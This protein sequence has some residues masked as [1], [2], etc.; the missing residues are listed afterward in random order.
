MEYKQRHEY[1]IITKQAI[2]A[3][4]TRQEL[5]EKYQYIIAFEKFSRI[6]T[7]LLLPTTITYLDLICKYTYIKINKMCD[8]LLKTE[9]TFLLIS[10]ALKNVILFRN[11][12]QFKNIYDKI[13]N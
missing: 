5:Y 11:I 12:T 3:G 6:S 8:W 9:L 1:C 4:Y 13:L 7:W 10:G 2:P